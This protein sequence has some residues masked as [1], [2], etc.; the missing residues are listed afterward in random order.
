MRT[1][2]STYP[3]G[4]W[5]QVTKMFEE[6]A[7]GEGP[8]KERIMRGFSRHL[9]E[10]QHTVPQ[11]FSSRGWCYVLEGQLLLIKDKF[12]QAQDL[13]NDCRVN[14]F[15][16]V[17]LV[18]EED[19][20]AFSGV[21]V[22]NYSY[23]PYKIRNY[24][25]AAMDVESIYTPNWWEGEKYYIQMIVEKIDLKEMFEPVCRQYHVPIATAKGWSSILQRA[26]FAR[27]FKEAEEIGLIPLLL[28][29]GDHDPDGLRITDN[30][31]KNLQDLIK[32]RWEDG[33]E[34]YDPKNLIIDRFG[35]NYDF[36]IQNN[37]TWIDNLITASGKDLASP[38]H[39]NN[40]LPYVQDYIKKY[41][42]RKCE[43]NA[44]VVRYHEGQQLC[45]DAIERHLGPDA[46]DR[47]AVKRERIRKEI[48]KFRD[49]TG[50]SKAIKK[51]IKAFDKE[52]G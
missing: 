28:Q 37:L 48:Q 10:L 32:A 15:L 12:D 45:R 21:E 22:P 39:P 41:G 47:F 13:V 17:D 24:L 19:A 33:T 18:L 50:L 20:R 30:I 2:K 27:R 11:K 52:T 26:E 25:S 9:L 7:E 34:G 6:F 43:A 1:F 4:C 49:R 23:P 44:L 3:L 29:C 31:R 14:N 16:P 8:R 35:L 36:I 5:T 51:V 42:A 46:I 38:T 40:H